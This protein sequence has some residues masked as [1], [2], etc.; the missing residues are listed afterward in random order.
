V[1]TTNLIFKPTSSLRTKQQTL[2]NIIF[3]LA[4]WWAVLFGSFPAYS[5]GY[6]PEEKTLPILTD[7]LS[8]II[9]SDKE[10]EIG[11]LLIRQVRAQLPIISDPLSNEYL[12]ALSYRLAENSELKNKELHTMIV[13]DNSINAFAMPGGVI[14]TNSGLFLNADNEDEF[15]AVL[16]HEIAHLSQ[17]HFARM[18]AEQRS[19]QISTLGA[20]LASVL[21][22]LTV[23]TESGMGALAATQAASQQSQLSFSRKN[24]QEADRI[25][26]Q[27]LVKADMNPNAMASFF[28]KLQQA[29]QY[30]GMKAPEYLLSHPVTESR[31]ADSLTRTNQYA[32]KSYPDRLDFHLIRNRLIVIS[33]KDLKSHI[34]S[35][36]TRIEKSSGAKL[37]GEQYGLVLSYTENK[38]FTQAEKLLDKL[39][40]T[41]P[42]RISYLLS[43]A[44]IYFEAEKYEQAK[45]LLE[46]ALDLHPGNYPLSMLYAETLIRNNQIDEA[47]YLLESLSIGHEDEPYVWR[48]LA[49]A[50]GLKGQ[51]L[52][53]FRA[54]AEY[55][56]LYGL[57]EQALTQLKYALPLAQGNYQLKSKIQS[58]IEF[59][60]QEETEL[61]I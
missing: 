30:S 50:H 52:G 22:L 37:A 33:S 47:I 51:R 14:A 31:I 23:G 39:Q 43:E 57:N 45:T 13:N 7:H 1:K 8:G 36:E 60:E 25:G 41:D 49:E 32:P 12:Q 10:K 28:L 5:S 26:M 34:K 55:F 48:R 24:E 59:I 4:F 2:K 46:S 21:V 56:F 19:N 16:A 35:L 54:K 38:Q 27:T 44:E 11:Q 53:V 17:R 3:S 20:Y 9:S 40:K 61:K 29:S 18:I 58:R 42:S 15:S 6:T